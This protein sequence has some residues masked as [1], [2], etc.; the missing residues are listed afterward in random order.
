LLVISGIV[1]LRHNIGIELQFYH[2]AFLEIAVAVYEVLRIAVVLDSIEFQMQE[3]LL[4]GQYDDWQ[5]ITCNETSAGSLYLLNKEWVVRDIFYF[6]IDSHQLSL[7]YRIIVSDRVNNNDLCRLQF[8][9]TS[10][11]H[12]ANA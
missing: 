6:V 4:M 2:I 10:G 1:S 7:H 9:V 11:K 3:T 5:I 12:Y 8:L